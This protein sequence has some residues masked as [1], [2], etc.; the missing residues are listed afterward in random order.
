[1]VLMESIAVGVFSLPSRFSPNQRHPGR[2]L[3]NPSTWTSSRTKRRTARRSNPYRNERAVDATVAG[4][5]VR[6]RSEELHALNPMTRVRRLITVNRL[7]R[8]PLRPAVS[9]FQLK[10]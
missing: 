8:L 5:A 3:L 9:G 10:P 7:P 6:S 2:A 1:M 4:S